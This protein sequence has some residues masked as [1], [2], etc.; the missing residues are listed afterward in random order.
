MTDLSRRAFLRLGT[1]TVAAGMAM[2]ASDGLV[3]A[4]APARPTTAAGDDLKPLDPFQTIFDAMSRLPLVAVAEL[5]FLQEWHD[6]ITSLLFHPA[7]PHQLTD[8]VVEFGNA[9]YQSI[10]D[11]FIFSDEPVARPS[12]APIWRYQ[13]WD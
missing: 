12:L 1:A 4:A 7:L 2:A 9:Q 5:H 13:G 10:A 8:I 6:F 11:R 3:S